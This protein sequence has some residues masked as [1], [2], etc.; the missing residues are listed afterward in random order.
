M[1]SYWKVA[2]GRQAEFWRD[3]YEN[4]CIAINWLNGENLSVFE[5]AGELKEAL[6]ATE[7]GSSIAARSIE[8]FVHEMKEGDIVIAN[9]GK[10]KVKGIGIIRSD[11]LSQQDRKN[12]FR[13]LDY[14]TQVRLVEWKVDETVELEK[15]LFNI[16]TVQS[17]DQW[18]VSVIKSAY[19]ALRP[20]YRQLLDELMPIGL[21]ADTSYSNRD[22]YQPNAIDERQAV[23]QQVMLRRGQQAFRKT[24]LDHHKNTCMVTGCRIRD[25][26]EAAHIRPYRGKKDNHVDNGLLLR[27][28]IHT[29]FDVDLLGIDPSTLKIVLAASVAADANYKTLNGKRITCPENWQPNLEA[30]ELRY[31]QFLNGTSR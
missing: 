23:L 1:K 31:K 11:Y 6:R 19:I 25:L 8:M 7:Q 15:P 16:P 14:N 3:C 4:K 10:S 13:S 27:A 28:D 26:L 20:R 29:L 9:D 30:L 12:P 5:G 17:L 2:P 18:Q 21:S 22:E 24:L